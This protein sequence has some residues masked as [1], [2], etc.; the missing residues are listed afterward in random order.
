MRKTHVYKKAKI[1]NLAQ[2][3]RAKGATNETLAQKAGVG[4]RTVARAR[5]DEA[6]QIHLTRC[7]S[8]ALRENKFKRDPRGA[9]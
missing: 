2:R 8:Q 3:M 4:V 9:R 6:I 5:S 7:I 1:R